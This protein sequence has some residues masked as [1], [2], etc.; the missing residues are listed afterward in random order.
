MSLWAVSPA[1][2]QIFP[3]SPFSGNAAGTTGATFL[4]LPTGGREDA[5]GGAAAAG[6]EGAEA[7][8]WNPAGLGRMAP[9]ARPE[10]AMGY[11]DLLSQTYAGSLAYA[12]PLG[13]KG[14]LGVGLDYFSQSPQTAYSSVGDSTGQFTPYDAAL[15]AAYAYR[16]GS[17][18]LGAG[19]K[20]I[21]S[22][23]A[24]TAGTAFAVD[25]GFQAPHVID[26]GEGPLD[27]GA[28]INNLGTPMRVGSVSAPLPMTMRLGGQWHIVPTVNAAL[29][30]VLP[31]DNSPYVA[32]G[33][34]GVMKQN[35][36]KGFLRLGY[37]MNNGRGVDGLGGITA[38][39]GVDFS[40][41]RLDY[42]WVPFGDLG[43][44]NRILMVFRF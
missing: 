23:I 38:G 2:S 10:L 29:D 40:R 28:S 35:G 25:L 37:D 7:M 20:L 44:T 18:L 31:V 36:W 15:G 13:A 11:S 16:L 9:E 33:L 30:L 27:A 32:F 26:L 34:E 4:T 43:T 24:D 19:A 39:V 1:A 3:S 5:M 14:V 12:H 8:F 42:A 17:Y 41:F 6:T 21:R 22:S